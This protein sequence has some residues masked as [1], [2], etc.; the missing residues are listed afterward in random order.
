MAFGFARSGNSP[1]GVFVPSFPKYLTSNVKAP[2]HM[3][4][5]IPLERDQDFD[6]V[7]RTVEIK[8]IRRT[9]ER[10]ARAFFFCSF[11]NS[12][13]M[14]CDCCANAI[15]TRKISICVQGFQYLRERL[16]ADFLTIMF[17]LTR[18]PFS[19]RFDNLWH[20]FIMEIFIAPLRDTFGKLTETGRP[21]SASAINTFRLAL[22][23]SSSRYIWSHEAATVWRFWRGLEG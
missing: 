21:D 12:I 15:P 10:R 5:I 17:H 6:G 11:G 23:S 7:R 20:E 4:I 2:Q 14:N 22:K 13:W 8:W 1:E 18:A 3:L 19:G 16:K 9:R